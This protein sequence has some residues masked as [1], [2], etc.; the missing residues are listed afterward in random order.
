MLGIDAFR[1]ALESPAALW[2]WWLENENVCDPEESGAVVAI[3]S[4]DL[5]QLAI[6]RQRG[7][8]TGWRGLL[9]EYWAFLSEY[10]G[11]AIDQGGK[12]DP[13]L[14]SVLPA[15]LWEP[16]IWPANAKGSDALSAFS[17]SDPTFC[18]GELTGSGYLFFRRLGGGIFRKATV[19][20]WF[21]DYK[22]QT[23][24]TKLAVSF[25]GFLTKLAEHCLQIP[26][27]LT[28]S[29]ADGWSEA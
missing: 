17:L 16:F 5:E 10:N 25:D 18:F 20:V 3:G 4:P 1:K 13:R 8:D 21:Y 6:A 12:G 19:E 2:T 11:V 9:D 27:L 23:P 14:A 24:E 29:G 26:S 7:D 28:A 15:E 22:T